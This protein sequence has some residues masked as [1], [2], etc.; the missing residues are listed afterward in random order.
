MIKQITILSIVLAL[1][2]GPMIAST[3]NKPPA[4]ATEYTP[5]SE[6][7]IQAEAEAIATAA[8]L[9]SK[10]KDDSEAKKVAEEAEIKAKADAVAKDAEEEVKNKQQTEA[11][12]AETDAKAKAET[13]AKQKAEAEV[14]AKSDEAL[15]A[16]HDT[17]AKEATQKAKDN[18]AQKAKES[19]EK[20]KTPEAVAPSVPVATPDA[21]LD[22]KL[23]EIQNKIVDLIDKRTNLSNT[24]AANLVDEIKTII[25]KDLITVNP[26]SATTISKIPDAKIGSYNYSN[27]WNTD[28]YNNSNKKYECQSYCNQQATKKCDVANKSA[29]AEKKKAEAAKAAVSGITSLFA[30]LWGGSADTKKK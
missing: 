23:K 12:K 21:K 18:T 29:E 19:A 2:Y 11:L 16:K 30:S 13:E 26:V 9:Q 10:A 3:N 25:V 15:K 5:E 6:A 4:P 17:V 14:K 8:E 28:S 24:Q 1:G 20:P 22:A 7:M 27:S